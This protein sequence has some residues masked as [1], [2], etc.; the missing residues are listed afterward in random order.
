MHG[1]GR[2]GGRDDA[3]VGEPAIRWCRLCREVD[4]SS[5]GSLATGSVVAA[6]GRI[7]PVQLPLSVPNMKENK[8]LF[9]GGRITLRGCAAVVYLTSIVRCVEG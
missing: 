6:V 1:D 7:E 8:T 5:C 3:P 9:S 2:W 4:Q